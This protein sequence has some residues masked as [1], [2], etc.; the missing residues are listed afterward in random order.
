MD[1]NTAKRVKIGIGISVIILCIAISYSAI[2]EF[3]SPYRYPTDIL[4]NPD[5][6]VNKQVQV[7]GVI[8]KG[9]FLHTSD[10]PK[11]Y[12]FRVTD[13]K[14]GIGV[15]YQG[16]L[17]ATFKEGTKVVVIGSLSSPNEFHAVKLLS[18]C[19]SKYEQELDK[20]MSGTTS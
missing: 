15:V 8:V 12:N 11:T 4:E 7:V 14:T 1:K 19:P 16:D 20:A 10:N 17:P 5:Q 9:S 2:S 3:T 13:G 6:Y 18:A